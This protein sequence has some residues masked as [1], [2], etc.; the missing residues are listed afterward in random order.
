M[1]VRKIRASL[2][3]T[4]YFGKSPTPDCLAETNGKPNWSGMSAAPASRS[5]TRAAVAPVCGF[6]NRKPENLENEKC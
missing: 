3:E 5:S 1:R 4:S 2:F 6:E